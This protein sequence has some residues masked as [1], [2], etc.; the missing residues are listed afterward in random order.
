MSNDPK[1]FKAFRRV[2]SLTIAELGDAIVE[3]LLLIGT[4][5]NIGE[6][7]E[8]A[9][10]L[11][12]LADPLVAMPNEEEEEEEGTEPYNENAMEENEEVKED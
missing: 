7:D 10:Y 1:L 8:G 6:T 12:D 3:D 11:E 2:A 4:K 5:L 9:K